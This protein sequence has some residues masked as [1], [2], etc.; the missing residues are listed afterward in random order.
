[1]DS[2]LK[3][4]LRTDQTIFSFKELSMRFE[5][6]APNTLKTRLHYY[7][8]NGD[9]YHIRRGLYA[10]NKNYNKFELAAKI[11]TPSYISFDTVLF[12]AGIIFQY[13]REIF[14]ASYQSRIIKCDDTTY[15][16]K[17]IKPIILT[18]AAGIE[19]KEEYCIASPERAFLDTVYLQKQRHFDN[20]APLNW[21]KVHELVPIYKN[22]SMQKRVLLYQ[23]LYKHQTMEIK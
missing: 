18:N 19:F 21:D 13:F 16:F 23:E 20:L 14:V 5:A 11:L 22:K 3:T 9:L 8:K 4:I 1:M 7:V 15:I 17:A 12:Q 6:I 2:F 10:K